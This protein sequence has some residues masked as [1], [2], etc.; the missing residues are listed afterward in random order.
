MTVKLQIAHHFEFLSLKGAAQAR[1]IQHLSK[2]Y[3]VGNL[4]PRLNCGLACESVSIRTM[5]P[6]RDVMGWYGVCDCGL[7]CFLKAAKMR[8]KFHITKEKK[9]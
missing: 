8:A 7:T 6:S 3:I 2:C 9:G 1:L 4:M 5:S